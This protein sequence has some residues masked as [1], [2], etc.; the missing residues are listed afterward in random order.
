MNGYPFGQAV[1]TLADDRRPGLFR[2]WAHVW[3]VLFLCWTA[4]VAAAAVVYLAL[5]YLFG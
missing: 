5:R 2:A 1:L 3:I 4:I